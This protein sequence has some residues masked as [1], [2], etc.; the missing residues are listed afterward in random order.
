M[1]MFH[2]V[3]SPQKSPKKTIS[4]TQQLACTRLAVGDRAG[5][6]RGRK[7]RE[8]VKKSSLVNHDDCSDENNRVVQVKQMIDNDR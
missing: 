5:T 8:P 2:P 7:E 6:G 3:L 4:C 1:A